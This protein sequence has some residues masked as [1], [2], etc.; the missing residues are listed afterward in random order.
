[1]VNEPDG[2][3][4][5]TFEYRLTKTEGRKAEHACALAGEQ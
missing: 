2:Q 1:M 3:F 5:I 4:A